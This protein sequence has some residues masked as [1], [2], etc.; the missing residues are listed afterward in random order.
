MTLQTSCHIAY[1][2]CIVTALMVRAAAEHMFQAWASLSI[3]ITLMVGGGSLRLHGHHMCD[4][5]EVTMLQVLVDVAQN[6]EVM[7]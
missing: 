5:A 6:P 7:M 3:L 4:N 2:T 1:Q